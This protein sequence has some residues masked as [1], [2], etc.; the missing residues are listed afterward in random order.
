MECDPREGMAEGEDR[1]SVR[2]SWRGDGDWDG[3]GD[4]DGDGDDDRKGRGAKARWLSQ[5]E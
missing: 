3:D 4:G 2:G 1:R 5:W